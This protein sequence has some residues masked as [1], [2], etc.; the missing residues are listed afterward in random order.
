MSSVEGRNKLQN[1]EI[2]QREFWP[3]FRDLSMDDD[4]VLKS[5]FQWRGL[6]LTA[7]SLSNLIKLSFRIEYLLL[8]LEKRGR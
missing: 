8:S 7:I 5:A 4:G 2:G 3:F 6:H 1:M